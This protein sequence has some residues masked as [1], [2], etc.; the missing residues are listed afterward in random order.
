MNSERLSGCGTA[1]VTP[2]TPADGIDERSL[3]SFVDWQIASGVHFLVPC[4][5]TGEAATMS[6]AEHRRVVEITVDQTAGRVPVVAG[7][8]SNDTKKAIALSR[9]M[10][11]AGA[12]HLLHASPMYN[13]PPQRGIVA[14]FRA[15]AD[16]VG[17]P[18]VV[19]NV[20]GRTASNI[21]AATT[22]ELAEHE[23]IVAVKEASGNLAQVS[24]IIRHRPAR[25]S[26]L[27]GDD[28]LTLQIMADGGDGVVSVTSNAAPALVAE[29]THLCAAGDFA[30]ARAVHHRLAEWTAAAFIES[31]PIPVK[32]ALAM[33]GKMAN[34]VRL[35][36]VPLAEKHEAVVR[37]AL[38]SVG[39]ITA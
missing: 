16:A 25:F 8:A 10:E 5:S 12:T 33:M 38:V 29:L 27:S 14:H 20:P 17:I 11:A 2:F 34:V 3:R 28:P 18:I 21:D 7:A 26:V 37:A 22:L 36:L 9:E 35:P 31:N 23:N 24:E 39:A 15:V 1:L 6:I 32:A 30:G 13:K 4:G 19:Y